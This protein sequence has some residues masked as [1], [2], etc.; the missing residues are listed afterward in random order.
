MSKMNQGI[1]QIKVD[2]ISEVYLLSGTEYFLIEQFRSSLL[3]AIKGED[4]E[5]ISTYDLL[6]VAIQ[7]VIADAET[8]PFFSD[9]KVIIAHHPTFLKTTA[10]KTAVTH[11]VSVLERYLEQPVPST[12]LVIIAPY[13]KLDKRKGITKKLHKYAKVID[14]QPLKEQ[15]LRRWM[16]QI[17]TNLH[18]TLTED[19][20]LL[21]ESE[22]QANLSMLQKE[23]EKLALYVGEGNTVTKEIADEVI[24]PSNTYNALQLVDAVLKRD[25][26]QAIKIFKD[27]EKMNED[28]I[29]LIALL[30]Y[31]FRVIFQVKLLK[32][33]G[34]SLQRIQSEVKV[35]PY[36]V[37]LAV[38]RS[39]SFQQARL[40]SII[41]KLTN[42]DTN[43]KRG[44][45][46]KGIAFEL[47]LYDLTT[48]SISSS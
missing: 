8:I 12:V 30:A 39:K 16:N 14:C 29:G 26:H 37:K 33:K 24:S 45:M 31:Q 28:P 47:L 21:L 27:L 34:Y 7:D 13:E 48:E 15:G 11:D 3:N 41:N 10:D 32:D 20:S 36:V 18:I 25:L 19:A 43:I 5:D 6:E 2:N 42:V 44:K 17:A 23:M 4:T 9:K 40:K 38:Q 46:E 22:F 1:H 35:H